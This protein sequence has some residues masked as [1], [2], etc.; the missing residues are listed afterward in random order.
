MLSSFVQLMILL[1][2][3]EYHQKLKESFQIKVLPTFRP[4][5]IIKTDDPEIFISYI[6]KLEQIAELKLKTL[7]LLLRA[8]DKRHKFFHD[9]GC[10]LSDHGLDRFYF[11]GFTHQKS[12]KFSGNCLTAKN[13][14][15]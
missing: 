8:I 7:M 9:M 11:T 12:T 3:L 2:H 13:I 15:R 1:I 5:N 6:R 14:C 4:D 10:R